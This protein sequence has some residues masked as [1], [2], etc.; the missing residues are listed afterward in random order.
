[1]SSDRIDNSDYSP[2]GDDSG[3]GPDAV[4]GTFPYYQIVMLLVYAVLDDLRRD[5]LVFPPPGGCVVCGIACRRCGSLLFQSGY[6]L[7]EPEYLLRQMPV[8][9]PEGSIVGYAF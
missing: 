9:G 2:A 3:L 1:M 4:I 7:R 8:L 6:R 5:E